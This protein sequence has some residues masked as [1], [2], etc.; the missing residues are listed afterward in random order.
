MLKC[1]RQN[2]CTG[3]W[4]FKKSNYRRWIFLPKSYIMT[5][6]WGHLKENGMTIDFFL[7][8]IQTE[9]VKC[10]NLK[11]MKCQES[12]QVDNH[13]NNEFSIYPLWNIGSPSCVSISST[14]FWLF[15]GL[16]SFFLDWPVTWFIIGEEAGGTVLSLPDTFLPFFELNVVCL[17][18]ETTR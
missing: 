6:V 11:A 7:K 13:T 16:S 15:W 3:L 5:I 17:S 18:A 10:H 12:C 14:S 1:F 4:T 8:K 9:T 2:L